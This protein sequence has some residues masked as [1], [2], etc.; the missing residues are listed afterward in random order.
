VAGDR[1][2]FTIDAC[3]PVGTCDPGAFT[4][5]TWSL[6]RDTLTLQRIPGRWVWPSLIA[7]PW[8]RVG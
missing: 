2:R 4:E 8:V 1:I 6:Y 3:K 7:K 5:Y